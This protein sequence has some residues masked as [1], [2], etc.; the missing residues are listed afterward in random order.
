MTKTLKNDKYNE[1]IDAE[2]YFIQ[3]L[4]CTG[5][6]LLR[7]ENRQ[8]YNVMLERYEIIYKQGKYAQQDV[9]DINDKFLAIFG[10]V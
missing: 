2:Y 10:I 3:L 9:K 7:T 5:R 6:D 1:T 4:F 8:L